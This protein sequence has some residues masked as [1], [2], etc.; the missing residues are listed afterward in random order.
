MDKE[1]F[2]V[3]LG[4]INKLVEARDYKGAMQIVDSIDWRRV[5][6]VRTLCV[7]GEIYAANKRYEESKEIFLLAYHRAPIGKNILYRLIEVSLKMGQ[8]SEATE[9]FDEYREVA[10]NDNSQYILRYK[11]VRAKNA[12]LNEQIRILEEYKEKEFTERWSYELA[13]LYYK[14][15][16]KQKC[17]DLCNE[18]ILWFNDGNYV[19]KA[20]DLKQRMGVLT[21]EEKEK[22]EQRFIPKLIPPEKAKEIRESKETETAGESEYEESRPVTDTIQVD[23]ERDLNSAETF[24]EKIS[25]GIRDIFGG[26]KKAAEEPEDMEEDVQDESEDSTEEEAE[27]VQEGEETPEEE[28]AATEESAESE[29][30]DSEDTEEEI[31]ESEDGEELLS[32]GIENLS[33][34]TAEL[35]AEIQKEAA[36]PIQTTEQEL[37]QSVAEIMKASQEKESEEPSGVPLNEE[38]KPDFSATIRMPQ[39]KIPKSMINVDP[40]N[41]SAAAKIP[42]ASE[43]FGSIDEIAAE[44]AKDKETKAETEEEQEFNLEDTILAAAT[45]QGIDIPEEEKSPDVQMSDVTEETDDEDDLDIVADEFVPEEPDAADIEDIMAQISAQQ[46]EDAKQSERER[47]RVPD[48]IL[49]ED[50]EP[51]TEEDMQAAEA[52]FL[53]GP[54]GV[55]KPV[56][57]DAFEDIEELNEEA[58]TDMPEELSLD[59][60]ASED[61]TAEKTAEKLDDVATVVEEETPL[62]EE[63]EY[64]TDDVS[65]QSEAEDDEED[66][67][68]SS[69]TEDMEEDD[70][71]E[72]LTEEEQLERFIEDIQPEID[73]NTIISRKRQLTDEE[74]QLFTYFVAVPG[75]KEQLLDVLCDVQTGAADHTSQTGNVIVMGGRETGKTRLISSLIPAICKELNIEASKVAYI[76]A[77]DLNGKNIAE[78]ASKLAGGFLVI[79]NANQLS[80]ETADELDEVMNGNTK[81]M[82]VIL[83]D[84]KIGMRKLIA[85]YPKFAKKFT[86]MINIPVFTNDE[87]VNFAKVYT[88]ENGFR[89]DQ[90]GMLA[91]YNLIGINQ[92]EDQPM[93]IGTVKTML[94]NAM[95]KAQG[96]LFKRSKKRVDRDGFTVLLEKD[97]S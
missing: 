38:G 69:L 36:E 8:I 88:M 95:A 35:K 87:L 41:A 86:S 11:I 47:T 20:L 16:D 73:P 58:L 12:S 25:K 62:D 68:I 74:K 34:G 10:G 91:L 9:F 54:A 70:R 15:G 96:G 94:D 5:K 29:E 72:E 28:T 40:E 67:F 24:Q 14:A 46:A 42:D 19:M 64:S 49:D 57:E 33:G 30:T 56:E 71:E 3:K 83:E 55:S 7:V 97:F 44:V 79:E 27:D 60:A 45:E 17:L 66:D 32:S 59:E 84:E 80:Q 93:C 31:P 85:R 50:E 21:G 23:D 2:R 4:E 65:V 43:I 75:M 37:S 18:M 52:E 6:N 53:N 48:L 1:E 77:E 81:S 61:D 89:I 26:H 63:E 92:K 22:Y 76:F 51:V 39:L 13:K 78:I 90:M 82:I